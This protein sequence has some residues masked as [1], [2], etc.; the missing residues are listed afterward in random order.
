M[1]V[2]LF[3]YRDVKDLTRNFFGKMQY[4]LETIH[5]IVQ[6]LGT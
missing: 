3:R 5:H 4:P 2:E 1:S 6:N